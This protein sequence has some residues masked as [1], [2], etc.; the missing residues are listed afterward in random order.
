MASSL[1]PCSQATDYECK[2]FCNAKHN[3]VF[4]ELTMEKVLR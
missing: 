4:K 2:L 1:I 3:Y